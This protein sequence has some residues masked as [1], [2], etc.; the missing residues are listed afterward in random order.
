MNAPY[1]Y[2]VIDH[3]TTAQI[4]RIF[5]K[6]EVNR[7][8]GCWEWTAYRQDGYGRLRWGSTMESAHRIVY[9]WTRGP[10]PRG[11]GRDILQLDHAVCDN[12]SCCNPAH[13]K[14]VFPRVNILRG[15]SPV[16]NNARR[17]HCKR[18]HALPLESNIFRASGSQRVCLQCLATGKSEY[19][20]SMLHGPDSD[21]YR[22]RRNA[23]A[24]KDSQKSEVKEYRRNWSKNHRNGPLR[25]QV[26]EKDRIK[27]R[28]R[29]ARLRTQKEITI[30]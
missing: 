9:A 28:E 12:R 5:S 11:K 29:R 2:L 4:R 21:E 30:G 6:V 27:A 26:L 18:G 19:H 20:Q 23:Q 25:E 14:L 16:A 1:G 3:L 24:R 7:D 22:A 17:T 13:L 8:T 10:I 15:K